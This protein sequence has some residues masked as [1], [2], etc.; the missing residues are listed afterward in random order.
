M[1]YNMFCSTYQVFAVDEGR[2]CS[3]KKVTPASSSNMD[4]GEG[5]DVWVDV[6]KQSAC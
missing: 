5:I 1:F 2:V 3:K 6:C 4:E